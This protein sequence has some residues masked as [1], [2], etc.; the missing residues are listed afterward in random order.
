MDT[1][2]AGK[3]ANGSR[4]LET[5]KVDIYSCVCE[6]ETRKNRVARNGGERG[7]GEIKR[8]WEKVSVRGRSAETGSVLLRGGCGIKEEKDEKKTN[9]YVQAISWLWESEKMKE[10]EE[11]TLNKKEILVMQL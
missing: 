7:R 10:L 4:L 9:K 8:D 6:W 3:V 2:R 11:N 1:Q 5:D